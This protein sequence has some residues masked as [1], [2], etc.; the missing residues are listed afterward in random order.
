MKVKLEKEELQDKL[1]CMERSYMYLNEQLEQVMIGFNMKSF[2]R[3][4]GIPVQVILTCLDSL[5]KMHIELPYLALRM[6]VKNSNP[7]RLA[8][9]LWA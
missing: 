4:V 3:K 1:H 9:G 8:V 7:S 2:A 5:Y 6:L